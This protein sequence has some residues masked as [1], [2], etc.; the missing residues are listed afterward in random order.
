MANLEWVQHCKDN[1]GCSYRGNFLFVCF[2]PSQPS[3]RVCISQPPWILV[4][5][6]SLLLPSPWAEGLLCACLAGTST[7]TQAVSSQRSCQYPISKHQQEV[8]QLQLTSLEPVHLPPQCRGPRCLLC[9]VRATLLFI[10]CP[11][12]LGTHHF[13]WHVFE[14][15][16]HG[17]SIVPGATGESRESGTCP[18]KLS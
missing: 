5:L 8:N 1:L 3:L 12:Y 9:S 2:P 6:L 17:H 7:R 4:G 14:N 13:V 16:S 11:P 10:Y 15:A 18:Q